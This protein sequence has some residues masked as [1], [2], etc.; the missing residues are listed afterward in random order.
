MDTVAN[1]FRLSL[2]FGEDKV[3]KH[4]GLEKILERFGDQVGIRIPCSVLWTDPISAHLCS[5]WCAHPIWLFV[6]TWPGTGSVAWRVLHSCCSVVVH[7]DC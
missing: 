4:Q 2:F 5:C 1:A 3:L 7:I 6:A